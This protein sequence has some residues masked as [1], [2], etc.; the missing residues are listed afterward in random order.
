MLSSAYLLVDEESSQPAYTWC[1]WAF[2]RASGVLVM[3]RYIR[4]ALSESSHSPGHAD[5]FEMLLCSSTHVTLLAFFFLMVLP[6]APSRPPF[7]S[8]SL[9]PRMQSAC[10]PLT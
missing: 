3:L 2:L 8:L 5:A 10:L 1:S 7:P 6:P 9:C 4:V